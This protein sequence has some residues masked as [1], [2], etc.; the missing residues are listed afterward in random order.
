MPYAGEIAALATA[1][2]WSFTS[3]FFSEAGRMI[4]SFNVNR[5][6]LLMASLIYVV[7]LLVTTGRLFPADLNGQQFFY[8]SLSG[9]IGLVLGD[10]CGF[11][12]LVMI[13]PR[14]TTL[15]YSTAPIITTVIAW[16][17]LGEQLRFIELVGI[18][19]T[20][21]GIAWVVTER[22]YKE[23]GR[24]EVS[25][26]HPDQGSKFKGVLLGLGAATGQAVGLVLAK[27]GMLHAGGNVPPM[28]ASLIRMLVAL[29]SIWLIAMLK[30]R[31]PLADMRN[32]RAMSFTF[33]GAFCGPFLGVWMSLVAV[34]LIETGIASTLN[35]T[36][37]V[38]ILPLLILYYREKISL[39]AWLGAIVA[40]AGVALLFVS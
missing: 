32:L 7:V 3:V 17:F 5:I 20:I 12:A 6:R 22:E 21:T 29:V 39:R 38:M 10:G 25:G 18:G 24:P 1:V 31:L 2:M 36:V 15:L 23:N 9:F 33:G 11:K 19:L 37:P 26:D 30:G 35:S 16:V 8:L 40:V 34:G 27:Q 4:G 13:G 14:L 28:E